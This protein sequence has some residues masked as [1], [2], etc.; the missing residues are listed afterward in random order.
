MISTNITRSQAALISGISL[1]L[2]AI[3]APIADFGILQ[4]LIITDDVQL[5]F[6]NITNSEGSFRLSILFFMLVVVLDIIV[7]WGLYI[8]LKPVNQPLSLLTAWFRLIYAG[9]LG[10]MAFYLYEALQFLDTSQFNALISTEQFQAELMFS[11]A[12]FRKGWEFALIVFGFHLLVLGYLLYK[13]GYMKK[14]LGILVVIAALGYMVDGIGKIL[15]ADYGSGIAI[16]TFIGEVVLLFWLIIK[17]RT[18]KD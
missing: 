17:G 13:A 5:T 4:S 18:Y 14:I 6:E 3:I 7:A 2:M 9:I 10:V 12:A 1:F 15:T 11:L 8:F 16:Y